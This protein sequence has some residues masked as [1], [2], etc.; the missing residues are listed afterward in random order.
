[1]RGQT[2]APLFAVG[3]L[4]LAPCAQAQLAVGELPRTVIAAD[5]LGTDDGSVIA[6]TGLASDTI[7]TRR[8]GTSDSAQLLEGTAGL[9]FYAGGGVSSL[10]AIDGLADDRLRI[11]VDGMTVGSS[12]PNH[13][14][15]PL[16]YVDPG[17]VRSISVLNGITPVSLGGDSIGGTI[18]FRSADP[19]FAAPGEKLRAGGSLSAFYRSNGDA[20]STD[21]N[22]TLASE[23]F[24][25][26]YTVAS[27]EA[28]DYT[29]GDGQVVRSTEFK[30][31]NNQ[32]VLAARFDDQLLVLNAGWQRVPYQAF[33][34][35]YMDMTRNSGTSFN[36]RYAGD[37]AWGRLEARLYRQHVRHA[38]DALADKA[39]LGL[40]TTGMPYSMP[41]QVDGV[42][43]GEAIQAN[44]RLS[45]DSVLRI[46]HEYHRYVLNDTWPA[47]PDS[48]MNGPNPFLDINDGRRERLALFG[49]WESKWG[50]AWSSQLGARIER[51]TMNTGPVQGYFSTGD[52]MLDMGMPDG[53]IYQDDANAFNAR[54]HKRTDNNLDVTAAARY[55]PDM[56]ATYGFGVAQ[57]TRSPNLYERYAWSHAAGMAGTMV[58]WFGDLNAYVGNLDLKPEVAHL[59]R[60][61]ANWH[62]A[63]HQSWQAS[64]A[65]YYTRVTD[66]INVAVDAA[67]TMPPPPGRVALRFVNHEAELY[68]VD[69]SARRVLGHAGGD[70]GAGAVL[71]F[72]RGRDLDA[73]TDLYNVMPL[74]ARVSLDHRLGAWSSRAELQVVGAKTRVDSIRQELPTAGYSLVNLETSY[75]YKAVTIRASVENLLDRTYGL[76]LGGVDF[77]EYNNLV[78]VPPDRLSAVPG[79]GRSINVGVTARF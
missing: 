58:S 44:V 50:P 11:L 49:E 12:C 65:P 13:M 72:T 33:A 53:A 54:D 41:V 26:G 66:Y 64:V 38:M 6:A 8:T 27:T 56:T 28:G 68:G 1:M 55:E 34:N 67:T 60:L 71:S 7:A 43:S 29:D 2:S 62:D 57:K 9:S 17:S 10:P 36:A 75:S 40:D 74:D 48:I 63:A 78:S 23:H 31:R 45:P 14:N 22:G 16:S 21:A 15:P 4:A 35:E 3:A 18:A 39:E 79:F 20:K 37:F 52:S 5:R 51:V 61:D 69:A 25:A 59:V 77:Y 73:G 32:V 42:D 76:P 70:W 47:I 46:G 19:V 24:Y 30:S